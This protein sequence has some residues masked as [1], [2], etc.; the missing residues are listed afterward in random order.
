MQG[1]RVRRLEP[2]PHPRVAHQAPAINAAVMKASAPLIYQIALGVPT[3]DLM[4]LPN[5][6]IQGKGTYKAA[7]SAFEKLPRVRVLFDNGAGKTPGANSASSPGNPYAGYEHSFSTF[8]VPGTVARSFYLAGGG[9][10][11]DKAGG[12][13]AFES[14]TATPHSGPDPDYLGA[15]GTGTGTASRSSS[16]ADVRAGS[17]RAAIT[18]GCNSPA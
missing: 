15:N 17:S 1:G 2:G 13:S 14:F 9:K 5:D 10:L 18:R 4:T 6:P 8:P 7:L 3:S 12:T 11:T 16:I